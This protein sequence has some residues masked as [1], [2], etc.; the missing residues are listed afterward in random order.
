MKIFTLCNTDMCMMWKKIINES[1]TELRIKCKHHCFNH[2][3][4]G[5]TYHG[6]CMNGE[7]ITEV[8]FCVANRMHQRCTC[9][10]SNIIVRFL[11]IRYLKFRLVSHGGEWGKQQQQIQQLE[12]CT[13]YSQST[14]FLKAHNQKA[15]LHNR[16]TLREAIPLNSF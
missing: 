16:I 11:S 14:T 7:E 13:N 8:S 12:H 4:K 9:F 15:K 2:W 3:I 5:L 6:N 1:V 10:G